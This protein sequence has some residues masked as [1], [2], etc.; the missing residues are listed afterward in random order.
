MGGKQCAIL[1][2]T[3]LLAWQ[4]YNTALARMEP[5]QLSYRPA[6]PVPQR[7]SSRRADLADLAK[8]SM[9]VIVGTHRLLSSD[10]HFRDLGLVII[11]EDSASASSTKEA[12]G[13]PLWGWICS[14]C[15]PP[16]SPHPEHGHERHPGYVHH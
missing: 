2:P 13:R 12:E 15:R 1:A 3:T 9:D 8:G 6:Q 16:H 10:V 14:P 4:H 7:Q 11:D 5:F